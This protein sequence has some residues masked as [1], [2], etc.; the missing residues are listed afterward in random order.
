MPPYVQLILGLLPQQRLVRML[1]AL[2]QMSGQM[3]LDQGTGQV[4]LGQQMGQVCAGQQMGQVC[5]G[6]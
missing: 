4:C 6:Q 1:C 2:Q 5:A 3:R